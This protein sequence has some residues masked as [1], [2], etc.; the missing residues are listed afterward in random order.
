MLESGFKN[1]GFY[2][3]R[4]SVL[5]IWI[6]LALLFLTIF[7]RALIP[8]FFHAPNDIHSQKLQRAWTAFVAKQNNEANIALVD[9][10]HTTPDSLFSFNPNLISKQNLM[11]LGLAKKTVYIWLHY[12][13]KGGH[14]YKKEDLKKL[15]TLSEA[16]YRRL[17]PYIVLKQENRT[18]SSHLSVKKEKQFKIPLNTAD[19]VALK[20]LPGIGSVF[21]S[22]IIHFRNALGGFYDVQQLKEVYGLTD[23]TY[24]EIA[25]RFII[26]PETIK[27]I[28]LNQA[29]YNAFSHHPYLRQYAKQILRLR[30]KLSEFSSIEQIKQIDKINEKNYSKI[31]PYLTL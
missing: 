7:F 24:K 1:E 10:I 4:K 31:E 12:R 9:S 13:E 18:H 19:T 2:L 22:R 28:H 25:D 16:D 29:D 15:Y 6:L 3:S 26:H 30:K 17:A 11:R 14:F 8:I 27:K 21:A 23:S 20:K 5:S